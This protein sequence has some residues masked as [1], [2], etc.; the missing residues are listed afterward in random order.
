MVPLGTMANRAT[1]QARVAAHM[2]FD[3]LW[4]TGF[5]SRSQAYRWLRKHFRLTKEECHIGSFDEKMCARVIVAV[6]DRVQLLKGAVKSSK[7]R[8]RTK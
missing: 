4:Q 8:Q 3:T 1:R 2:E 5:L 7:Q 6:R